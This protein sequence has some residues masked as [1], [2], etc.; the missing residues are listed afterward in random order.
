M[1]HFDGGAGGQLLL[2]PRFSLLGP[3]VPPEW[4]P[5]SGPKSR[6]SADRSGEGCFTSATVGPWSSPWLCWLPV[7][8]GGRCACS[9]RSNSV[10]G[11]PPW[12]LDASCSEVS[13]WMA[14]LPGTGPGSGLLRPRSDGFGLLFCMQAPPRAEVASAVPAPADSATPNALDQRFEA[15]L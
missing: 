7:P 2:E 1:R 3:R 10:A 6:A 12:G 5:G 13:R 9:V 4:R 15:W 14:R 11:S 8:R